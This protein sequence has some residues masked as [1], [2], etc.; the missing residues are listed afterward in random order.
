MSNWVLSSLPPSTN[1]YLAILESAG[2]EAYTLP[3]SPSFRTRLIVLFC[4]TVL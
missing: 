3:A 1:A 4:L 2:T